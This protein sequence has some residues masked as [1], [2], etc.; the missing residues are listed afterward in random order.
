MS[1]SAIAI[2]I[3]GLLSALLIWEGLK[4]DWKIHKEKLK[5]E[6][7]LEYRKRTAMNK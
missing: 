5:E 6:A 1:G 2:T 4:E 7:I 3:I